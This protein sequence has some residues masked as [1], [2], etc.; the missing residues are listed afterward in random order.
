VSGSHELLPVLASAA[1]QPE[2]PLSPKQFS[3]RELVPAP[4]DTVLTRSQI[5]DAAWDLAYDGTSSVVDQYVTR[6]AV[7]SMSVRAAP[8]A[9][10]PR[11][12]RRLRHHEQG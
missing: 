12:G 1:T 3:L 5:L 6:L 11:H 8:P 4:S 9:D 10:R 2:L 7:S